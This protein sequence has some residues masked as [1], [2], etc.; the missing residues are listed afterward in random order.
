MDTR[1]TIKLENMK[2]R[3]DATDTD[4]SGSAFTDVSL[5]GAR[6]SDVN[7]AAVIIND[8]NLSG[9]RISNANLTGAS[10]VESLTDGMTIDGIAVSDLMTAYR[11]AYPK[12]K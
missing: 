5:S 6:F 4:M 8:A 2:Q 12:A 9:L 10:I 3:I 7:L 1:Q 11:A